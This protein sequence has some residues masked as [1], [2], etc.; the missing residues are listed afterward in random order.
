MKKPFVVATCAINADDAI[1]YA[2][3][4]ARVA[5]GSLWGEITE[6]CGGTDD[7]V[8]AGHADTDNEVERTYQAM[9]EAE[10]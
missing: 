10:E 7:L 9:R 5:V 6:R 4:A 3:R 8:S 2:S 1:R